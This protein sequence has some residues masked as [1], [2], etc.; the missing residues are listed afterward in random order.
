MIEIKE[1]FD[2]AMLTT[3]KVQVRARFFA[4]IENE[5]ELDELLRSSVW[6][7]NERLILGGGSNILFIRNFTGIVV[8]LIFRGIKII[9]ENDE[10]ACVEVGGGES[11]QEL[12][13]FCVSKNYGGVENLSYIPGSVGA[14]PMQNIGAYGV[15]LASVVHSVSAIDLE[16]GEMKEFSKDECRFGYRTSV[17]KESPRGTYGIVGVALKLKKN[18][19]ESYFKIDYPG[20]REE[21]ERIG[22]TA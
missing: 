1:N 15:E 5:S 7:E 6:R 10:F 19:A 2:L 3:F 17:F 12:V 21:I 11:W 22:E 4:E 14:A 18:P 16:S 20:V 13:S 9:D 8:R